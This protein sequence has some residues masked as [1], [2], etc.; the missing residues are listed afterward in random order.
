MK[1][2]TYA[3]VVVVRA[4]GE[5]LF[6][7]G[8]LGWTYGVLTQLVHPRWMT[9]GLS[10]LIPWIRIDTFTIISFALSAVGFLIWRITRELT[11]P[12]IQ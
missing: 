5:M 1:R 6:L 9:Y 10:H 11:K 8:L 2:G 3:I 12:S 4:V 7:Y